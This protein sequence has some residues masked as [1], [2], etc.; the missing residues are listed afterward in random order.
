MSKKLAT[1]NDVSEV[2]L[3]WFVLLVQASTMLHKLMEKYTI[4][5]L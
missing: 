5:L 2:P 3:L 4:N 1:A